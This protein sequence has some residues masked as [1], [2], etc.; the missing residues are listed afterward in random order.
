MPSL[1]IGLKMASFLKILKIIKILGT[2]KNQALEH[3]FELISENYSFE[4][5]TEL[6]I[7][8]MV[9]SGIIHCFVCFH[10]FIGKHSY[11]NWL[12]LTNSEKESII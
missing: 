12:I 11:S 9:F 1:F 3:F 2:K 8:S 10:I 5:A 4:R 7:N 6:I